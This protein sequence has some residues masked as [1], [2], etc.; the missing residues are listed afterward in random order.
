M[1][2]HESWRGP[3]TSSS[4]WSPPYDKVSWLALPPFL[5]HALQH[6]HTNSAQY[7]VR[8]CPR[9]H[10]WVL[11]YGKGGKVLSLS[12]TVNPVLLSYFSKPSFFPPPLFGGEQRWC[13]VKLSSLLIAQNPLSISEWFRQRYHALTMLA[14]TPCFECY[15]MMSSSGSQDQWR[16]DA[17]AGHVLS[18]Q[19][20]EH[21]ITWNLA[22]K[23]V[24]SKVDKC[25][26][27]E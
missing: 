22:H 12:S 3:L 19:R 4:R 10:A 13:T 25:I 23:C 21:C 8:V 14:L 20:N 16:L 17:L 6:T 5:I 7:C 2:V 1:R 24:K 15:P 9:A 27:M 18:H 26:Q 11:L